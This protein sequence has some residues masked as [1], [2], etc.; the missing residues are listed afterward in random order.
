MRRL[1]LGR[2]VCLA[3]LLMAS[4][5]L[6]A[7]PVVINESLASNAA[8]VADPQG[9]YDDWIELY[10]PSGAPV[11]VG[12]MYLTDDLAFPLQ[13]R[14]PSDFPTSTTIPA[15]GYLIVW[16][17][18]DTGIEGLHASF[19]LDANGEAIGLFSDLPPPAGTIQAGSQV[20]S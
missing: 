3:A 4:A 9:Q 7:Q 5:G 14:I 15:H 17:D 10:N 2:V 8:C 12:G 16:A 11:D 13:Y 1:C 20:M 6:Q 19:K 18:G